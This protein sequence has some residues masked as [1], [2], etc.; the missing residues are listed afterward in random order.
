[1][2]SIEDKKKLIK[3]LFAEIQDFIKKFEGCHRLEL[4]QDADNPAIFMTYSFWENTKALEKYRHSEF[5]KTTWSKV[6]PMFADKP[7]AFSAIKYQK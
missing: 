4:W 2:M 3:Q 1:M 5:F 7:H 6:K